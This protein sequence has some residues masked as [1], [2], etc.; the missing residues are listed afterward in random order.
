[1][2][3]NRHTHAETHVDIKYTHMTCTYG[4]TL[5]YRHI[6]TRTEMHMIRHPHKKWV[7][8]AQTPRR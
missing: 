3:R 5:I 2:E 4:Q 6:Y 8:G 7:G 1:M